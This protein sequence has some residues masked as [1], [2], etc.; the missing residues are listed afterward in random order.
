MI[1]VQLIEAASAATTSSPAQILRGPVR[2]GVAPTPELVFGT[3]FELLLPDGREGE[4]F[5][6]DVD[7]SA[8][9]QSL[10][11]EPPDDEDAQAVGLSPTGAVES[12][13]VVTR[14]SHAQ[15][16]VVA[17]AVLPLPEPVAAATVAP[18]LR[19]L[20]Q[21]ASQ[22]ATVEMQTS[23][24]Q[25]IVQGHF[26]RVIPAVKGPLANVPASAAARLDLQGDKEL[27]DL[28]SLVGRSAMDQGPAEAA[29]QQSARGVPPPLIAPTSEAGIVQTGKQVVAATE[30]VARN[31]PAVDVQDKVA[32][33]SDR[34]P[35]SDR[36]PEQ[37]APQANAPFAT[38][39]QPTGAEKTEKSPALTGV[40]P[41][42]ATAF[43]SAE[44]AVAGP[45][46]QPATAPPSTAGTETARHVA[47][48]IGIVV[49]GQP[50]GTTEIALN[51]EELGRVRLSMTAVD[52]TITLN[53]QA[54][55][56]ETTE[57]LRRHIDTLVQEFRALG[58]DSIAF[59]FGGN[60][61]P[62]D[63]DTPAQTQFDGDGMIADSSDM[64]AET[65]QK[66][67]SQTL[68]DLRM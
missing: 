17:G 35:V 11:V 64:E 7:L 52:Q 3:V 66:G 39:P 38:A 49:S 27:R 44:R 61:T 53:L 8:D 19:D 47:N 25:T 4:G 10:P 54:E 67:G 60:E 9:V 62:A 12:A 40:M 36:A 26:P 30:V 6:P 42:M 34:L 24:A 59:S 20:P 2:G 37:I 50:G 32:P 46:N 51:P 23:L 41:D 58:Y 13:A 22:N 43:G 63:D 68:L 18:E 16:P 31:W 1:P 45:Q 28:S 21:S 5:A 56:P 48:Q 65:V 57:L 15:P 55:R 33:S 14:S 29:A